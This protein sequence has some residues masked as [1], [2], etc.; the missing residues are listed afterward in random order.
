MSVELP[1][2]T[3]LPLTG[4]FEIDASCID[5]HL[6]ADLAPENFEGDLDNDVHHVCKQPETLDELEVVIDALESC[7]TESILY[8][9]APTEG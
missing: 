3:R 9:V 2:P 6:C 8:R 5:C 7:P 4:R 1:L